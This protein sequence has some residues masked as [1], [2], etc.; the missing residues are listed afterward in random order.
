MCACFIGPY[1]DGDGDGPPS[2]AVRWS[3]TCN[4]CNGT[5][6]VVKYSAIDMEC[7]LRKT[8]STVN[9]SDLLLIKQDDTYMLYEHKNTGVNYT[10]NKHTRIWS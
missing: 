7:R 3:S 9:L 8:Y 6:H 1:W 10:Y 2:G 5:G 4:L